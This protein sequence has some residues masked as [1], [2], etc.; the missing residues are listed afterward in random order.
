M[1]FVQTKLENDVLQARRA[2]ISAMCDFDFIINGIVL[3]V[4][5]H[6]NEIIIVV[7]K[8]KDGAKYLVHNDTFTLIPNDADEFAKL[9]LIGLHRLPN[10]K[11]FKS[12]KL[13]TSGGLLKG[14]L[15]HND[16]DL[17]IIN[18]VRINRRWIVLFE[19]DLSKNVCSYCCTLGVDLTTCKCG[20]AKYCSPECI[21]D[22]KHQHESKCEILN[23]STM[24]EKNFVVILQ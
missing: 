15:E 21:R 16:G 6:F 5:Q 17:F 14:P 18:H 12:I 3:G 10:Y 13:S 22:H 11:K 20:V 2:E 4:P 24:N 1:S 7:I 9:I 8:I 23:N 19:P